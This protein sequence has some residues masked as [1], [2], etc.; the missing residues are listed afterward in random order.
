MLLVGPVPSVGDP[1]DDY[2]VQ[3][4]IDA[5]KNAIGAATS[6]PDALELASERSA[7]AARI[8]P[9]WSGDEVNHRS[10]HSF[11]E[12]FANRSGRGRCYDEL[13]GSLTQ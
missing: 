4:F 13:G 2:L 12:A 8:F 5:I 11:R 7:Y 6:T 10:R 1:K 3:F 9:Q